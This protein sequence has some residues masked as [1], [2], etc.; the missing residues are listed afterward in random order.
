MWKSIFIYPFA[1]SHETEGRGGEDRA[2]VAAF[3]PRPNL[4]RRGRRVSHA[5]LSG[6]IWEWEVREG[7]AAPPLS[8]PSPLFGSGRVGRGGLH[9]RRPSSLQPELRRRGRGG[10][11]LRERERREEERRS[12]LCLDDSCYLVHNTVEP[13]FVSRPHKATPAKVDFCKGGLR[14]SASKN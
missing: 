3:P 13:V 8:V 6:W 4:G 7:W 9:H 14:R 2:A 1:F 11:G 12:D 10:P 5:S